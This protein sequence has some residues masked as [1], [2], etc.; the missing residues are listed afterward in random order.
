VPQGVDLDEHPDVGGEGQALAGGEREEAVLVQHG[1]EALGPVRV[2][3][4]VEDDP[5]QLLLPRAARACIRLGLGLGR[6]VLRLRPRV[7]QDAAEQA[8]EDAVAPLERRAVQ[9]AV[10]LLLAQ[11]LG[12]QDVGLRLCVGLLTSR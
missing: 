9:R 7:G 2:H 3:V 6:V 12:V 1:V 8:G 11:R 10:E 4:A 5:V